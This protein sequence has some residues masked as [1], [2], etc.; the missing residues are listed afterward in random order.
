MI[1]I[2]DTVNQIVVSMMC[3]LII[4]FHDSQTYGA[5]NSVSVLCDSFRRPGLLSD[6]AHVGRDIP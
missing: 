1:W 4:G 3:E 5:F 2:A 6:N